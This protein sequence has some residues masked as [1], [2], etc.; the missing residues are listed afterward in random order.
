MDRELAGRAERRIQSFPQS[1]KAARDRGTVMPSQSTAWSPQLLDG[2]LATASPVEWAYQ[3]LRS[4][5]D[6]T[7]YQRAVATNAI[8]Q[9]ILEAERESA[10]LE[11]SLVAAGGA[12]YDE[13][14]KS[15]P[16]DRDIRATVEAP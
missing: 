5:Y 2:Y 3:R 16:T 6:D 4:I 10:S 15:Q 9:W 12:T 8:P 13:F 14:L 7:K 11:L 1:A